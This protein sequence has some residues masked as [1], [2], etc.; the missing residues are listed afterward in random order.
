MKLTLPRVLPAP[1]TAGLEDTAA[2]QRLVMAMSMRKSSLVQS[3]VFT[4]RSERNSGSR[5]SS[6]V[7]GPGLSG[8]RA[9]VTSAQDWAP[10][11]GAAGRKPAGSDPEPAAGL[12]PPS[13][14]PLDAAQFSTRSSA[15]FYSVN[16]GGSSGGSNASPAGASERSQ[17]VFSPAKDFQAQ[18][19]DDY[20]Q[21]Y[22]QQVRRP[23][24]CAC[25]RDG[26]VRD[27]PSVC[28]LHVMYAATCI[29]LPL[30]IELAVFSR[31]MRSLCS[32]GLLPE[33]QAVAAA[34]AARLPQPHQP[35]DCRR[36]RRRVLQRLG[37][38]RRRRVALQQLFRQFDG[39][40]HVAGGAIQAG[41]RWRG[42]AA[43]AASGQ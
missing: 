27:Q 10:R 21:L 16:E 9:S 40:S 1:Q 20:L 22:H 34:P 15:D 8:G 43:A 4:D 33:P 24:A 14:Q 23:A 31:P 3:G 37:R 11:H 2:V 28:D 18:N 41:R 32:A 35:R 30:P 39:F 29:G 36:G 17:S 7:A 42:A 13:V 6:S 12:S 5:A 26:A 38:R 19:V 25:G